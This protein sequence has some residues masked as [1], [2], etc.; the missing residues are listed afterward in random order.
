MIEQLK[1]IAHFARQIARIT[2]EWN[3]LKT[4]GSSLAGTSAPKQAATVQS[5]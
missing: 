3:H 4:D 1:Q 5:E 2:E